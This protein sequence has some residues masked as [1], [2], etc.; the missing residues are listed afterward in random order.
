MEPEVKLEVH[1]GVEVPASP[2]VK[3]EQK[4][5]YGSVPGLD[6]EELADPDELARQVILNELGPLLMLPSKQANV[7]MTPVNDESLGLYWGAFESADFL[8]SQPEFD[9]RRYTADKLQEELKDL[10]VLIDISSG[11]VPGKA[12]YAVLRYLERGV[13]DIDHIENVDMLILARQYLRAKRLQE[14]VKY[15]RIERW[16]RRQRALLE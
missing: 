6:D 1:E 15:L 8:D 3:R 4:N 13:I 12:K 9:K 11:H 16:K 7:W 14:R 5:R 10:L 2:L